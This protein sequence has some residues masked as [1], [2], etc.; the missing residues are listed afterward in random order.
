MNAWPS[1]AYWRESEARIKQQWYDSFCLMMTSAQDR[2]T[3]LMLRESGNLNWATTAFYYSGVHAGRLLCF[4]CTGDY[5]TGHAQL[6]DLL[7]IGP[8]PREQNPPRQFHFD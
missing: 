4:V 6:A 1:H 7:A 3:G 8:Q 5:P 2:L